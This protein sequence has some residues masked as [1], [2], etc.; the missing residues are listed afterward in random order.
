[1]TAASLAIGTPAMVKASPPAKAK[2]EV[3]VTSPKA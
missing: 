3:G 1:M 2:V